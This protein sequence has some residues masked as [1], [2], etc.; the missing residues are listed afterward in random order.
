M[1][2]ALRQ[3]EGG[4][5]S[6][7]AACGG[8][9]GGEEAGRGARKLGGSIP[10]GHRPGVRLGSPVKG[11]GD[12]LP[13]LGGVPPRGDPPYGGRR[14]GHGILPVVGGHPP[15]GGGHPPRGDPPHG[16]LGGD[17]GPSLW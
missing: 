6:S 5:R 9:E 16:G 14:G 7:Q 13:V 3:M 1:D 2:G 4:K 10:G 17:M 8:W 12:T 15:H 11:R